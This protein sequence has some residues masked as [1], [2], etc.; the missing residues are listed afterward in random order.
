MTTLGLPPALRLTLRPGT[1]YYFEHRKLSSGEPHFFAIINADPQ[2]SKVLIMA[3]GS[4]QVEKVRERRRSFPPATLVVVDSGT[5]TDFS[6]ETVFDCNQV[7]ELGVEELVQ[8]FKAGDLRHHK[9]LPQ[10]ILVQ[11]WNGV[12][13]SPRVDEVHKKM[14]PLPLA[15]D[16]PVSA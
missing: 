1:V 15:L 7:F 16:A 10:E 14:I 8:K 5:Y 12:R 11:I 4:S 6:K 2:S 9:D 13:L 3:V